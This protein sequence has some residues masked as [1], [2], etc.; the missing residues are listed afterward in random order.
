MHMPNIFFKCF[1]MRTY[2]GLALFTS[3]ICERIVFSG[4]MYK[5][6]YGPLSLCSQLLI[7][8]CIPTNTLLL[9]PRRGTSETQP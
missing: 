9:T 7:P 6:P 4:V 1:S 5:N 3:K 2:R 8:H